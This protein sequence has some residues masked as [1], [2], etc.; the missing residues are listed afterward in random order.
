MRTTSF[1]NC[2]HKTTNSHKIHLWLQNT[3]SCGFCRVFAG[4]Y[5]SSWMFLFCKLRHRPFVQ[6][7]SPQFSNCHAM[8]NNNGDHMYALADSTE[9]VDEQEGLDTVDAIPFC[10]TEMETF[11]TSLGVRRRSP[12]VQVFSDH[13][14]DCA[15]SHDGSS[16][17]QR[18]CA[19][20]HRY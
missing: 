6:T 1:D 15:G 2:Q 14:S 13:S 10:V 3:Q 16:S 4:V 5:L 9:M 8:D 11:F 20:I 17:Q 18:I 19:R 7:I 12:N